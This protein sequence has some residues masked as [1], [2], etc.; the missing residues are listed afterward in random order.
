MK[1]KEKLI[2]TLNIDN[3][4]WKNIFQI[5]KTNND[6]TYHFFKYWIINR[7]LGTQNLLKKMNIAQDHKCRLRKTHLVTLEHFFLD[8][9]INNDF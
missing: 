3:I 7:I 9:K 2:S 4:S 8:C 1:F 5:H 6:N